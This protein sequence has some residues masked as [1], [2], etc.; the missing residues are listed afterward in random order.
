MTGVKFQG[1]GAAL[2]VIFLANCSAVTAVPHS[3][4]EVQRNLAAAAPHSAPLAD[5]AV[6]VAWAT[7]AAS[8]S[9]SA[10]GLAPVVV[11]SPATQT[12][13]QAP[14]GA[15]IV[16]IVTW[17]GAGATGTE[18][19]EVDRPMVVSATDAN[20]LSLAGS[21]DAASMT[22][23]TPSNESPDLLL[24]TPATG[25]T[26][27]WY[28]VKLGVYYQD[29][30]GRTLLLAPPTLTSSLANVLRVTY[31]DGLRNQIVL[32]AQY[33]IQAVPLT[34]GAVNADASTVSAPSIPF[35]RVW[36]TVVVNARQ[37][38]VQM[39]DR[40]GDALPLLPGAFS[41]LTKPTAILWT[42][43]RPQ[44]MIADAATNTMHFYGLDGSTSP[45]H[46]GAYPGLKD[47]VGLFYDGDAGIGV[48]NAGTNSINFYGDGKVRKQIITDFPLSQAAASQASLGETFVV[49]TR[50][51]AVRTY[52][53]AEQTSSPNAFRGLIRPVNLLIGDRQLYVVD[54]GGN[55]I[56]VFKF[57]GQRASSGQGFPGLTKPNFMTF[58]G[59]GYLV[60]SE[61][62]NSIKGFNYHGLA[63]PL[64]GGFAGLHGPI[65]MTEAGPGC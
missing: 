8:V 65:G 49:S 25:Y 35:K 64:P 45:Y 28:T 62:D 50:R 56:N 17:T 29:S 6:T 18:L 12:T 22:V 15:Q 63:V 5:V 19:G 34:L 14:V 1:A 20:S 48:V 2:A 52:E 37:P 23:Y 4:G 26:M 61:A 16:K 24:G 30:A 42:Q 7:G 44:Y 43:C 36:P 39:F 47:P 38:F 10:A 54:Q 31:A 60:S 32:N 57:T 55:S 40:D 33:D 41:G 46:N 53:G 13:I 11:N 51:A 21:G 27:V 9:L 59:P 58:G 3:A